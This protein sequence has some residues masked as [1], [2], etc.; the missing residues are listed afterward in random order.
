MWKSV[1]FILAI[2]FVFAPSAAAQNN[3][4]PVR[5]I[6]QEHL[7]DLA[8]RDWQGGYPGAPWVGPIQ[9]IL[10]D[11]EVLIGKVSENDGAPR[12]TGHQDVGGYFVFDFGADGTFTVETD[13]SV[14]PPKP[15]FKDTSFT[16]T[17][18]GQGP[19]NTI[20]NIQAGTGKFASATG[21][22]SI[23][24]DFM[25]WN[26]TEPIPSGRFNGTITGFLCNVTP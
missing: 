21:N 17:F 1:L 19:V 11:R 24:G 16:G 10:G 23:Q 9:L 2:T 6:A 15:K 22:F 3:C 12:L 13:N 20:P 5:G 26:L 14:F 8:N 7:L 18:H 25:A 4:L